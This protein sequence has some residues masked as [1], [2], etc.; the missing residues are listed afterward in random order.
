MK[1]SHLNPAQ[2]KRVCAFIALLSA[3]Y[4]AVTVMFGSIL[5]T[6]KTSSAASHA[7]RMDETS[8][9]QDYPDGDYTEVEIGCYIE[10]IRNVSMADSSFEAVFYLWFTWEGDADFSPGDS[11]QIVSG[12]IVDKTLVSEHYDDGQ[13]YQRYKVTAS[14]DK[15][16]NLTR[17]SLED[18]MLNIYIED[19]TRDG[20][21]LRYV[22]DTEETNISSRVSVPGFDLYDG[23][24]SIVKPHVYHSSYSSPSAAD[25][26]D[27]VFSQYIIAVPIVR[28]S[29]SFYLRVLIPYVL[30]VLLALAALFS[31][32]TDADSLGLS[33]CAFFG[34]V[35]NAY[36]VSSLIPANGGGF[37]LLD[38]INVVSLMSV[39][40]VVAVSLFSLNARHNLA[41]R[42]EE[43]NGYLR[44]I[45]MSAFFVIGLG[46]LLFNIVLPFCAM[47]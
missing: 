40:M 19:T 32:K 11:F 14:I 31:H 41:E 13:N 5:Y 44:A 45:D 37:G 35:A 28:E 7:D 20:A 42:E 24:S 10:S 2:K 33:G 23:I 12:S 8:Y 18:H 29:V 15:Y 22:A 27:R 4:L 39:L 6:S 43:D 25:G 30:S 3:L 17:F 9:E 26:S 34:V 1:L 16:Y 21:V 46:Y 38:M 47:M 36:V